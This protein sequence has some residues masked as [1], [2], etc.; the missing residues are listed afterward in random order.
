VVNREK[1]VVET[2]LQRTKSDERLRQSDKVRLT[3]CSAAAVS[4]L[5]LLAHLLVALVHPHCR[6]L[7]P[8][9][10]LYKGGRCTGSQGVALYDARRW[11]A[12]SWT[13]A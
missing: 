4:Q 6:S 8:P 9:Y 1:G 12:S 10:G 2:Q 11:P 13:A 7:L 5:K 3:R